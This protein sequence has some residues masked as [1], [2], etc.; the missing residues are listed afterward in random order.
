MK[1]ILLL[2]LM[3]TLA[4]FGF[5]IGHLEELIMCFINVLALMLTLVV[6]VVYQYPSVPGRMF[7]FW[8][9]WN[10]MIRYAR[11]CLAYGIGLFM[12]LRFMFS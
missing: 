8:L 9:D 4:N 10:I 7:C 1:I 3:I 12:L 6:L 11:V 2:S 5:T